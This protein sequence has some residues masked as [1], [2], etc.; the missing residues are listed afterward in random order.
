MASMIPQEESWQETRFVGFSAGGR[1]PTRHCT[2]FSPK[3][4]KPVL[5]LEKHYKTMFSFLWCYHLWCCFA[6]TRIVAE[7]LHCWEGDM[8]PLSSFCSIWLSKHCLRKATLKNVVI[9]GGKF[10]HCA[11][12][13]MCV[14]TQSQQSLVIPVVCSPVWS[15]FI[16]RMLHRIHQN[17]LKFPPSRITTFFSVLYKNLKKP[18]KPENAAK[19]GNQAF[20]D[21]PF[22]LNNTSVVFSPNHMQQGASTSSPCVHSAGWN[23]KNHIEPPEPATSKGN[24]SW[25]AQGDP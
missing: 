5:E 10:S 9:W 4:T 15:H 17:T 12:P 8:Q 1:E 19:M 11:L 22:H 13:L 18:A 25:E 23:C 14:P 21:Q 2:W 7:V 20:Y 16:L 6:Q 24:S 3:K